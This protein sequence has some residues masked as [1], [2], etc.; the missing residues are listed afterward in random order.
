MNYRF[1]RLSIF[2]FSSKPQKIL[3]AYPSFYEA[4]ET[5]AA[6]NASKEELFIIYF[7]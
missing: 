1:L 7:I 3:T 2:K 5:L 4:D 6:R